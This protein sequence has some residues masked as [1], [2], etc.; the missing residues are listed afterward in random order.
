MIDRVFIKKYSAKEENLRIV[1][2]YMTNLIKD[3]KS[4]KTV[5]SYRLDM[6]R[7]LSFLEIRNLRIF[8]VH[9]EEIEEF[10]FECQK[11][12]VGRESIKRIFSCINKFYKYLISYDF[13]DTNPTFHL[14]RDKHLTYKLDETYLTAEQVEKIREHMIQIKATLQ[15]NL[16]FEF[17]IS[18]GVKSHCINKIKINQIDLENNRVVNVIENPS[19]VVTL[20]FSDRVKD[21][22]VK[23]LEERKNNNRETDYLFINP[24]V[25]PTNKTRISPLSKL[26]V[27]KL[28]KSI[29]RVV[30]LQDF[31]PNGLRF[32]CGHLLVNGGLTVEEASVILNHKT[33]AG[34]VLYEQKNME[35]IINKK[36]KAGI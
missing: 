32:T 14:K 34:S 2:G 23:L 13:I 10:F 4:E 6:K 7:F 35:L 17:C 33:D 16:L 29:G 5:L 36:N 30:D 19:K 25:I 11:A 31:T 9:E 20:Y 15:Y 8:D 18:T 28:C 27:H 26:Q 22:I 12:S 24:Q 21:L 1:E 3:G